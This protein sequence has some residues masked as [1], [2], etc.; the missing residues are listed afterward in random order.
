LIGREFDTEAELVGVR[1]L[2]TLVLADA[3]IVNPDARA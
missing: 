3:F 1:K 2:E